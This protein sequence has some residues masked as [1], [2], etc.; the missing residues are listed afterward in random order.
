[1]YFEMYLLYEYLISTK[2]HCVSQNIANVFLKYSDIQNLK[3]FKNA[4]RISIIAAYKC[5]CLIVLGMF[6]WY[7]NS[8]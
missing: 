3:N 7:F 4:L 8:S 2:T 1:M 5:Q 6:A